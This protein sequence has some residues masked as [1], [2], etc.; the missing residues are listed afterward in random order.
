MIRSDSGYLWRNVYYGCQLRFR[1]WTDSLFPLVSVSSGI[2]SLDPAMYLLSKIWIVGHQLVHMHDIRLRLGMA[3]YLIC[4][5]S[6][7]GQYKP[8]PSV[9]VT[10][11]ASLVRICSPD[12]FTTVESIRLLFD[13]APHNHGAGV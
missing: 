12:P 3:L 6:R 2:I 5:W 10:Q 7:F 4:H 9:G 1:S 8:R 13:L 11:L